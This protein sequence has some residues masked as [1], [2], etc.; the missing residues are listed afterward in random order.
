MVLI[1]F[2]RSFLVNNKKTKPITIASA[3]EVSTIIIILLITIKFLSV[4]GVIAAVLS[5]IIGRFMANSYL[6]VLYFRVLKR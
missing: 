6:F 1:S 4:I 2:Q 5:L 3:I